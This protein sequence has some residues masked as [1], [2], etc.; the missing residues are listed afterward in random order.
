MSVVITRFPGGR[1]ERVER[2]V[3]FDPGEDDMEFWYNY[4]EALRDI[5]KEDGSDVSISVAAMAA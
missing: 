3:T 1:P 5:L 4:H 2:V